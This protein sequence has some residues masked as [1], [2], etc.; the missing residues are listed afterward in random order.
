MRQEKN[1]KKTVGIVSAHYLPHLGGVERYVHNLAESLSERGHRVVII[2]S[3]LPGME[4]KEKNGK[5]EIFRLPCYGLMDGRMPVVR[6]NRQFRDMVGQLGDVAFDIMIINTR[7]YVLSAWGAHY[8]KKHSI[9][10]LLVEHG[11]SHIHFSG[12]LASKAGELYEHMLTS[13]IKKRCKSFYGVSKACN[14]WLC[15]FGIKAAGVLYNAVNAEEGT[16]RDAGC[17]DKLNITKDDI[18]IAFAGRLIKE[19]GITKLVKAFLAMEDKGGHIYLVI[20]GDGGL[21]GEI[22]RLHHPRIIMLGN[23][24]H[25]QVIQLLW[26][27][28]VYCLPTDYPEGFP[29]TVLEAAMCRCCIVATGN[30]GTKEFIT[31][32][33]YGYILKENTV[34]EIKEKLEKAAYHKYT[35]TQMA[36]KACQR[37][38]ECFTWDQTTDTL[39]KIWEG[40]HG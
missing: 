11:T 12:F 13:F 5:V 20:A 8:C 19:K 2:T 40:I 32:D 3:C 23:I 35:A 37:V 27:T 26:E 15:H 14:K 30:G 36:D 9:P 38:L 21:A 1:A 7:L 34:G 4:Q 39:E 6:R 29:T 18:I 24:P 28:D 31:D 17:R 16:A 22:R 33:T 25:K 10:V